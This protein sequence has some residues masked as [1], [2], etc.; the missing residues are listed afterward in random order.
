MAR[1]TKNL[2]PMFGAY[3]MYASSLGPQLL[4]IEPDPERERAADPLGLNAQAD[5]LLPGLSVNTRRARYLTFF[6]WAVRHSRD[7]NRPLTFIHQLEGTLAC[8]EAQR[9]S[10]SSQCPDI[11][12][13]SRA[14]RYLENNN[15]HNPQRPEALYK[16]MAYSMYRPL[17]RRLGLLASGRQGAPQ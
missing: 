2:R 14:R 6:C 11:V 8:N 7:H 10:D 4:W 9:H 3:K 13:M 5:R 12:G 15:W 16:N 1:R 17:M